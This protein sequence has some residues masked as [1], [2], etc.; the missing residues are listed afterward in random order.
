MT[1]A[2]AP[3]SSTAES[4]GSSASLAEIADQLAQAKK[5]AV[6]THSKPDGDAIGSSLA[7]ARALMHRGT[8]V[9][10]PVVATPLYLGQWPSRF[11][12][13]ISPT[14]IVHEHHACWNDPGLVDA[15]AVVVVDTGS[16]NQVADARGYID[17]RKGMTVVIDHHSHGDPDMSAVRHVDPTAAAAAE[18]IAQVA[19]RLLGID[20][21]RKLP[22]DIAEPLYLGIATDTGWF[23]YPNTTSRTL[24][25]AADLIDAGVDADRLFQMSEQGDSPARL[26]LMERALSSLRLLDKD[27][28]A[29]MCLSKQD[30]TETGASDDEYGGIIDLPKAVGSIRVI[31]LLTELEPNLTKASFRSKA[32][33]NGNDEV[34]VNLVAQR[35]NGGGHKH[36]AGAKI[37]MPL[38]E[39]AEAVARALTSA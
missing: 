24:R 7:L 30:F 23:R 19:M 3:S 9:G 37:H 34:D 20:S 4:W 16:W 21:P 28:A 15:D 10:A 13:I 11:D 18:L 8:R 35:F 31:V 27:R 6:L 1:R 32:S 14:R 36:A 22:R 25:L 39:A 5:I 38:A 12:P 2:G 26:R 17:P 33:L 29:I